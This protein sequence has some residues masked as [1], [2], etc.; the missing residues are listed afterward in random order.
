MKGSATTGTALPVDT[1]GPSGT[2][3]VANST[4]SKGKGKHKSKIVCWNCNKR[5]HISSQCRKPKS[6]SKSGGTRAT[7]SA[8]AVA[9]SAQRTDEERQGEIDALREINAALREEVREAHAE[10]T[11]A[12]DDTPRTIADFE[13][14]IGVEHNC[15]SGFLA[16]YDKFVISQRGW[17]GRFTASVAERTT[18][19]LVFG[20]SFMASATAV[21][22]TSR[23]PARR[24][25]RATPL[26]RMVGV[27]VAVAS[28]AT[29]AWH[30]CQ[31]EED[32]NIYV[33]VS[34][35]PHATDYACAQRADE[36]VAEMRHGKIDV[37]AALRDFTVQYTHKGVVFALDEFTASASLVNA[38]E[39]SLARNRSFADAVPAALHRVSAT[40]SV[41]TGFRSQ[42]VGAVRQ[43]SAH[44]AAL[45][46]LRGQATTTNLALR[47]LKA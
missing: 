21:F 25:Q 30:A 13:V 12:V 17:F 3:S 45:R 41:N 2:P 18:A 35:V 31:S 19:P 43:N 20:A 32:E 34:S 38:C 9:E 42:N 10:N 37:D 4:S 26:G 44:I 23:Q 7:A 39:E 11:R 14:K 15:Y 1:A 24:S 29:L 33:N 40:C 22:A 47:F 27:G 28:T 16:V 5:G 46:F 36:R 8:T 6:A